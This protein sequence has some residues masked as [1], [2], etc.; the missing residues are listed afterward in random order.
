M[1]VSG[2]YYL[3][4]LVAVNGPII[5]ANH[6][7]AHTLCFSQWSDVPTASGIYQYT[8]DVYDAAGRRLWGGPVQP[9]TAT[10]SP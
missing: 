8:A 9:E 2:C 5:P 6:P 7:D 3:E 1:R 4:D 10:C